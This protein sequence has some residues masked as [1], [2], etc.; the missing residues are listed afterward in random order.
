LK[1]KTTND[2]CVGTV[3]G[4][5]GANRF[6]LRRFRERDRPAD[7]KTAVRSSRRGAEEHFPNLPHTIVVE[8]AA[9]GPEVVAELRDKVQGLS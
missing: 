8:N 4:A 5:R 7:T 2:Y 9:N 3:W 6:L 1:D